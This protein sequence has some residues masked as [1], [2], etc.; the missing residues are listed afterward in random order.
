M[1]L[2]FTRNDPKNGSGGS[3]ESV[4]LAPLIDMIFIL[5]IFF[6]VTATF[7]RDTGVEVDK[8]SASSG[9]VLPKEHP[10]V[11]I[12]HDGTIF[13]GDRSV[14]LSALKSRLQREINR[15]GSRKVVIAADRDVR[16]KR[17]VRVI[18]RSKQAGATSVSIATKKEN[19]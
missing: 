18:D 10:L 4:P 6:L 12:R 19:R 15:K 5:L 16:T 9:S 11:S 8:P 1:A 14:E 2:R 7:T 3:S 13:I 17:L